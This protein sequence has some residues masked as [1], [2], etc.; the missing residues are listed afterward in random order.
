MNSKEA[1]KSFL[2]Q[3]V[4]MLQSIGPKRAEALDNVGVHTVSDLFYY[5]PRRYLDRST[6]TKI[7]QLKSGQETTVV[8]KIL[9]MGVKKG[10]RNRFM[11]IVSDGS[12]YLT[13]VWF[14]KLSYWHRAFKVGEWLAFSGK[15]NFFNGFQMSH[16]EFDRLGDN[17]EGEFVHTGKIIPLYPSTEALSKVGLDSRGFRRLLTNLLKTHKK[18]LKE[19]L[20]LTIIQRQKLLQ[21]ADAIENIHFPKNFHFLGSAKQRLKFDELFYLE[22]MVAFRKQQVENV[23]GGIRFDKVGD[24]VKELIDNLPFELTGAQKKVMH[25]IRADMKSGKPMN[26]LLQGDVGSGKTMVALITMLIAIENGYQAAMMAPTEILAEQHYINIHKL[27]NE[28][29]IN[30]VLLVGGQ[31]KSERERVLEDIIHGHAH[32]IIG[33]HALI[34]NSVDFQNLGLVIIDEQHRFGVMQRAELRAKGVNPDV[35]VMTATPIPRTLSLTVYGDLDV[36]VLDELPLGR[37]P[38]KTIWRRE[39][40]RSKIYQFVRDQISK[41]SQAYVVFPLV[42]ESEKIDLKAAADSYEKMRTTFFANYKMGLLHG[43][44][45]S[46]EKEKVMNAFKQ[47]DLQILVSTTVIEVGVDVP[48]ATIMI[49][50]HAERF[51]LTQLHQ[52]RGR[53]GRGSKQSYCILVGYGEFSAEGKKRLDTM[54]ETNDGFKIAEV[55]LDLRGPGEFFGTRQHGMPELKLAD[56]T[57]D[58]KILYKAREEAFKLAQ[59]DPQLLKSDDMATRH[60]FIKNYR[61]KYDLAWVG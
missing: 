55:D 53:V 2:E 49:I 18:K 14:S 39:K 56:V 4:E 1:Q 17:G 22:L 43:R 35:L 29:G 30:T 23:H 46:E 13:C 25:E 60:Y 16:P 40:T 28:I 47:G 27:L 31:N 19:T 42:E 20:P 32:I 21:L 37:K 7:I 36:S 15:V 3:P 38:I 9:R 59:E 34:Q 6:V 52:L 48:N 50:E 51:G 26:R 57:K 41:G 5:F 44:M 10:R 58:I 11:L 24:K 12:S 54:V 33:T 61:D 8:A 45:K